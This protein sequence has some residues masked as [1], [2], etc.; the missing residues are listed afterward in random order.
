M[1]DYT[2]SQKCAQWKYSPEI[3]T[4][5]EETLINLTKYNVNNLYTV[6]HEK[7]ATLFFTITPVILVNFYTFYQWKQVRIHHSIII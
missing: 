3:K 7:S 2:A 4:G 1:S 6:D 5:S